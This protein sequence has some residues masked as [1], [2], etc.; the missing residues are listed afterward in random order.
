MK[1]LKQWSVM[2]VVCMLEY[3]SLLVHLVNSLFVIFSSLESLQFH[4]WRNN[5]PR[6]ERF[7]LKPQILG[8]LETIEI[9]L[10]PQLNHIGQHRFNN[11]FILAQL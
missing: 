5:A 10:V 11:Y 3:R 6:C 1:I 7:R 9:A 4:G 2:M 8:L